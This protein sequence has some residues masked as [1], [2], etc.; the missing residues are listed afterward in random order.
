MNSNQQTLTV[1]FL[2]TKP[3]M[4]LEL[5]NESDA[6][7]KSVEILT[8]FL[9]R[10]ESATGGSEAH[11]RFDAIKLILP[12]QTAVISHRTWINGAPAADEN[13]QMARLRVL[14]GKV[15]PYVLDISWQDTQGKARFQRIPVG[16]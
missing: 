11:I 2:E 15:N 5:T 9:K 13:D 14:D 3:R 12:Q 16:H 1:R 8:I 10:E 6:A 7:L 4:L